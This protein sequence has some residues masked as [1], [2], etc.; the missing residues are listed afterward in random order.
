M[1]TILYITIIIA[2]ILNIIITILEALNYYHVNYHPG[3]MRGA[4]GDHEFPARI[5]IGGMWYNVKWIINR[6]RGYIYEE[7]E[8]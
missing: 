7:K 2:L 1:R 6:R 4:S 5:R 3:R 8:Q